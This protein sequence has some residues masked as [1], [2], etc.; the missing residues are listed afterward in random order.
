MK[1]EEPVV[2]TKRLVICPMSDDEIK[3]LSD[4][5][6][7]D[8]LRAAYQE[9]L[10]G[11]KEHP[12]NRVWYAPWSIRLKSDGTYVGD[13][14]FKGP[15]KGH[16][17]EI[18]YGILQRYEKNGYTT[19]AVKA[20]A[21]WAFRNQ[22]ILFLEAETEPGNHASQRV[23]EKCGFIPDGE[24]AEGPRFVLESPLPDWEATFM[25]LGIS[26][27]ALFGMRSGMPGV[28]SSLGLCLGLCVG[29]GIRSS[30]KKDREKERLRRSNSK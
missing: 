26:C 14:G 17:V 23:L 10:T 16:A 6:E 8:D 19:E 18:G 4:T 13:L 3:N 2:K 30:A 29:H 11:C 5:A 12:E 15:A 25:L 22:D 7:N 28:G 24:G 9:M 20:M 1:K 27:G 21:K